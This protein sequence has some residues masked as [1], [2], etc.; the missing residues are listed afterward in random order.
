MYVELLIV[1]PS[2][3][4]TTKSSLPYSPILDCMNEH[5]DWLVILVRGNAGEVVL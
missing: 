2:G 3:P 1:L 5:V 4:V